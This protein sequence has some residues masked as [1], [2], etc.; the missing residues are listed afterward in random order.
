M[1]TTLCYEIRCFAINFLF[2][3]LFGCQNS[4]DQKQYGDAAATDS[5]STV[6]LT[7]DSVKLVKTAGI[8]LKVKNTE[9]SIKSIAALV[10]QFGG[11]VTY[12]NFNSEEEKRNEL[13]LSPDSL[14]VVSVTVPRADITL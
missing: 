2:A 11:S 5:T 4:G 13:K 8:N 1:E 10:K 6:I 12:Q 7:G 14:L 9:Q 3:F